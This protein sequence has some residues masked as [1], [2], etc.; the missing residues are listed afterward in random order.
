MSIIYGTL[1]RLEA[2]SPSL[3]E[4]PQSASV[5][6]LQV[7]SGS[8]PLKL[9]A[10]ALLV[11][12]AGM[13]LMLWRQGNQV[14]ALLDSVA[15][16]FCAWLCPR[17]LGSS[18]TVSIHFNMAII[19]RKTQSSCSRFCPGYGSRR[20][21]LARHSYHAIPDGGRSGAGTD[22]WHAYPWDHT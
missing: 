7:A 5:P 16:S 12:V 15:V 17:L 11:V 21:A 13:S 8:M 18:A 20:R 6:R 10:M 9:M 19:Y 14:A 3:A 2:E 4:K 1:E 22:L